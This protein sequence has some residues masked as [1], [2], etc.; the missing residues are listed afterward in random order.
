MA[1]APSSSSSQYSVLLRTN[2]TYSAGSLIHI[3]TSG[4]VELLTFAPS[5]QYQ[6]LAFSSPDLASGT[7]YVVY[8]NGSSTGTVTDGLYEGGAY[9]AGSQVASFTISNT[10]TTINLQ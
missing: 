4:G 3:Q 8:H 9:T 6:S 5:K 1:Q 7:G 2:T 10:V